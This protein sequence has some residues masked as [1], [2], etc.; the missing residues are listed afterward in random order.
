MAIQAGEYRK[1]REELDA[2]L[3]QLQSGELDIEEATVKYGRATKI[4]KDLEEYIAKAENKLKQV[5]K[6]RG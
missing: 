6:T 3:S 2:I 4:V 1:L 5:R